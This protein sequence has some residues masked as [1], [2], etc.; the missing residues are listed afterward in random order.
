VQ[1]QQAQGSDQAYLQRLSPWATSGA[2]DCISCNDLA[3]INAGG[4]TQ[5]AC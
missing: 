1:S 4:K 5:L 3:S 2:H